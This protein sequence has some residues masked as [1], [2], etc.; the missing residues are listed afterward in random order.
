MRKEKMFFDET[1]AIDRGVSC[2]EA[3]TK[4]THNVINMC[5]FCI[6]HKFWKAN[7]THE[8]RGL[9]PEEL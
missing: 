1:F 4:L 5:A 3:R 8:Y 7:I 9:F 2:H 6:M